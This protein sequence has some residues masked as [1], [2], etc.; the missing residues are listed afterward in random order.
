MFEQARKMECAHF[1]Q[2]YQLHSKNAYFCGKLE[3]Q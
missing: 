3:K 1:T 2:N